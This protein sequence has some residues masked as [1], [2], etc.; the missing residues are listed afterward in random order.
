[1]AH[2]PVTY[3]R[4]EIYYLKNNNF[5]TTG[6]ISRIISFYFYYFS[7]HSCDQTGRKETIAER[8]ASEILSQ[9]VCISAT[10]DRLDNDLII[11]LRM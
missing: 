1:M 3:I 4:E 9:L 6:I 2:T 11:I 10:E 5:Y 8:N 7:F